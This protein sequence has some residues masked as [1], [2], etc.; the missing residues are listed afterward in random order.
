MEDRSFT[1]RIPGKWARVG[2][3]VVVTTLIVAPLAAY[4]SHS[5]TDVPDTQTFHDDIAWMEASGVTKGCNPPDNTQYC[6]NEDVTRAQMAAF[7]HRFS[8]YLGAE[9][10]TPTLADDAAMLGGHHPEAYDTFVFAH[11]KEFLDEIDPP[12]PGAFAPVQATFSTFTATRVVITGTVTFHSVNTGSVKIWAQLGESLCSSN[13]AIRGAHARESADGGSDS[14]AFTA[15]IS[16]PPGD[17]TLK[18]CLDLGEAG[19]YDQVGLSGVVSPSG[20]GQ[21]R[22]RS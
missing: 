8:E 20:K 12:D 10:G 2:T 4:A 1:I 18:L 21:V 11:T 19:I 6:P 3:T 17:H 7:M 16:L 14:A 15:G 13:A 9:D 5:F 22:P